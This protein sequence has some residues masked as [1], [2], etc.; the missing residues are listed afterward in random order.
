[1]QGSRYFYHLE[2]PGQLTENSSDVFVRVFIVINLF[3]RGGP[4]KLV[5]NGLRVGGGGKVQHFPGGS[6]C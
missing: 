2:G 1:M 3:Y 6:N 4:G 5:F